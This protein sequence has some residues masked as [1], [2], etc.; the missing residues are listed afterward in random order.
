VPY[1][2]N[3][4]LVA[5]LIYLTTL[6]QFNRFHSEECEMTINEFGRLWKEAIV[7]YYNIVTYLHKARTVEP[8]K[9]PLLGNAR[10]Q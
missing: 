9:E 3:H 2:D 6:F 5:L 7:T 8:E 1:I 4:I 10:T